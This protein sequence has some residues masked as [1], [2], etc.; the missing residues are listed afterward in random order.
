MAEKFEQENSLSEE[1]FAHFIGKNADKYLLKFRKFN[2]DGVDKFSVTWHWPAFF[3][4]FL[5]ML[6]R[7]LYLWAL[8]AFAISVISILPSEFGLLIVIVWGM[9]GNY[10]YYK[11]AKKK[12]LELKTDLW[13]AYIPV[14]KAIEINP[15]D[16]DAYLNRGF[17][18]GNK[19]LYDK[20]ISDFSK[21]TE[22]NPRYAEAY[23]NRGFT[24]YK[25]GQH[26]KAISDYS[27]ALEINPRHGRAYGNRIVVYIEKK[28]YEKAWDDVN[29]AQDLGLRMHPGIL[30]ALR[31]A[32]G[33][34]R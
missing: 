15:R 6:Y 22:I 7:K 1:D 13:A 10:I 24:Y 11:H 20:A 31:E 8:V 29:K 30:K 25:K 26:D 18:Y 28:E 21:A 9:T 14:I 32:S 12:I 2:I 5:W 3:F 19:G 23:N 16:A 27:K 33:R 34:E 17:A 4:G